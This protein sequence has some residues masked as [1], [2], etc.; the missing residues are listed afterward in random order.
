MSE[1]PLT[2]GRVTTGVVRVGNTVRRPTTPSSS[3]VQ[4]L[5]AHLEEQGFEAA[6]RHLGTDELGREVL[7][8]LPGDVPADLDARIPDDAL[9]AAARLIRR[10]HDATAGTE[11]AGAREIVCHNDLS[12]C[13]FVF[14]D[15]E[16]VGIIDWD[17]AAPGERLRDLG[18]ALFLWLNLGTDGLPPG[19]QSRRIGLTCRAYGM[20]PG[21]EVIDAVVEAVA[22]NVERLQTAG[23]I[24]DVDWWQEQHAWLVEHRNELE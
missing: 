20:E 10:L 2:G 22:T 1:I 24:A 11:L 12:P 3:F 5:L 6:P 13:N 7:S 23:R 8:F 18:Y 14:R 16:P 9:A 4:A 17:G 15:G 21:R 19:E